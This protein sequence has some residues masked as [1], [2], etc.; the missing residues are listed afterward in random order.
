MPA[1]PIASE[2]PAAMSQESIY[3]Y[4]LADGTRRFY[5]KYRKSDGSGGTK[6][7]FKT[8]RAARTARQRVMASV[9]RGDIRT[10]RTCLADDFD[11]WL[12]RRR[13]YLTE[14]TWCDYE[15]HGRKR[16]KPFFGEMTITALAAATTERWMTQLAD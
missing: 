11:A 16:I 2:R 7:G 3:E 9:A 15:V 1:A 8:R 12:E 14:G 5:F 4:A 10:A 13:P 6:R